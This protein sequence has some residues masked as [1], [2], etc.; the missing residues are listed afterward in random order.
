M[1]DAWR[2]EDQSL[3]RR[4]DRKDGVI[5]VVGLAAI[6]WLVEIVNSIDHQD[7]DQY[8]IRPRH[9]DRLIGI[10]TSPFLH[11]SFGH[12]M[13]NTIPFLVLGVLIALNGLA[14]VL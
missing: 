3:S 7:L 4:E 10:V 6:M 5:V 8:G 2:V 1:R 11:A 9:A 14:R 13:A 12:L